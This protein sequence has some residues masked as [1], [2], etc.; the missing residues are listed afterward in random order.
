MTTRSSSPWHKASFEQL[1]ETRLPELLASRLPLGGYTVES[2]GEQTCCVRLTV[3]AGDTAVAYTNIPSPDDDGVFQIGDRRVVVVPQASCEQLDQAE[4]RCVG[5]QLYDFIE[6]RLG[7]APDG[8]PWD[9]SLVRSW[10]PLDSWIEEFFAE[11]DSPGGNAAV[12]TAVVRDEENWLA[13]RAHLRRIVIPDRQQVLAAG[14]MGRTC[15]FETPEGVNIGR[16]LHVATGAQIRDGRL[17]IVDDRPEAALGVTASMVPFVEHDDPNRLLMGCNMMRQWVVPL[18]PEPALVQSGNEPDARG[19]WCGRNLLTAFLSLGQDTYEDAIVLSESAAGRFGFEHPVEPGDKLS[20]RH[21][22]KGT[23]SRVLPDEQMPHLSDGTPIDLVFN[24]LGCHTRMNF[25]QIRE[26]AMGRI[27]RVEGQVAIVPPFQAPSADQLRQRLAAVGLADCGMETL[28]LSRGGESLPRRGTAGWV[29]WGVTHHLARVKIHAHVSPPGGQ[30]VGEREVWGLRDAEA[31]DFLLEHINTRSAERADADTLVARLA[32]GAVGQAEP[33]TPAFARLRRQLAVAGIKADFDGDRVSFGFEHSEGDTLDLAQPVAHPWCQDSKLKR[34]GMMRD[35]PEYRPLA[36]ANDRLRRLLDTRAPDSVRLRAVR[37][38]EARLTAYLDAVLPAGGLTWRGRTLF[39]GRA[40]ISPGGELQTDQVGLPDDIA[41]TLFGPLVARRLG[42]DREVHS[43]SNAATCILDELMAECW[44]VIHRAPTIL[45]TSFLAFRP[46]RIPDRVIRIH[47]LAT[48][49][50][51]ADFDGDQAAVFLPV[52]EAGQRNARE[53]LSFAGHLQRDPRLIRWLAL[54]QDA[55]WGLAWLSLTPSGLAEVSDLAGIEVRAPDGFVTRASLAE[56]MTGLLRRDGVDKTLA[57]IDR[58]MRRGFD[59]T[60]ESGASISPFTGERVKRPPFPNQEDIDG[61][62][63]YRPEI[64]EELAA[65]TDYENDD[66]GPQLLA[67]KSEARGTL[68]WLCALIAGRGPV[69]DARGQTVNVRRGL[70]EGLSPQELYACMAGARE[71]L[72]RVAMDTVRGAYGMG[73][74]DHPKGF[75]VLSR[76]MRSDRPGAVFA[77]AA[78][79]GEID[80][81]QHTESRLFVG[82]P[83][84]S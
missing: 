28:T 55:V 54:N 83:P 4:I 40:V 14:Q 68:N 76:A 63:Q 53:R 1:M 10:L 61:W 42:G 52:T 67:V 32:A 17:R 57:T 11:G 35:M 31:F 25:G 50:M 69:T 22:T 47:P 20:N 45:P 29:Y 26:A 56:A 21:G 12:M 30:I 74:W 64:G 27:A 6:P 19:F 3:A 7:D 75:N 43:R 48:L 44:V 62:K 5:E 80:P 49:P 39:S 73:E 70:V 66:L 81:L 16:I 58:L 23:V 46:V 8:L 13:H 79:T 18:E 65:R 72:G 82:L 2:T 84:I 41:W 33:P 36:E 34:V 38:L 24:F 9:E 77:R 51:N 78:A 71:A 37:L 15:P 59:V 60:R